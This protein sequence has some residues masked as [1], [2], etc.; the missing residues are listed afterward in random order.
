MN[1][2][3]RDYSEKR[4]F[5]RMMIDA[6]AQ[7]TLCSDQSLVSGICRDLSGNGMQVALEKALPIGTEADICIQSP[8]GEQPVLQARVSIARIIGSPSDQCLV[9]M[10]IIEISE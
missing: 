6:P 10:E 7:L 5:L 8:H 2:T 4:N 3:S 9:G 1:S